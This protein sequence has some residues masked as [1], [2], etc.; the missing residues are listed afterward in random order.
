MSEHAVTLHPAHVLQ[1][2]GHGA[3]VSLKLLNLGELHDGLA[4]VLQSLGSQVT[5]GN[6]L[7]IRTQVH[8]GVLLCV[9]VCG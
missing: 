2:N 1:T 8:T 6:V 9:A 7:D 5:A 4:H 3:S